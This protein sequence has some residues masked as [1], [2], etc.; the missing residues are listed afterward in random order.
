M[1]PIQSSSK[2]NGHYLG[3]E[4]NER[5]WRRYMRDKMFARGNG[6]FWYDD[7]F[8]F[9]LRYLTSSPLSISFLNVNE[10]KIGK[11]H[12]GKWGAGNPVLKVIWCKNGLKLSSG[13][14]VSNKI[15]ELEDLILELKNKIAL[16]KHKECI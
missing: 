14:L 1:A 9:F 10:F 12:A 3:T 11:W 16:K 7:E 4:I 15:N 13:F 2:I 5:W 8:I 6:E